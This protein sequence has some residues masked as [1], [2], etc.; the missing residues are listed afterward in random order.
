MSSRLFSIQITILW[1]DIWNQGQQSTA[2]PISIS[3]SRHQS[4]WWLVYV[5]YHSELSGDK[6]EIFKIGNLNDQELDRKMFSLITKQK[7]AN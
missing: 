1:M 2:E 7:N 6:E 4:F 3:V 5:K